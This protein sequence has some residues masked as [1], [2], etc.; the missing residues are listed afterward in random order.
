MPQKREPYLVRTLPRIR[1]LRSFWLSRAGA[2]KA[3]KGASKAYAKAKHN[4]EKVWQKWRPKSVLDV[5]SYIFGILAALGSLW[6][7]YL[8]VSGHLKN[9]QTMGLWVLYT[10]I[11]FIL[12]GAFLH[13]QKLIWEGSAKTEATVQKTDGPPQNTISAGDRPWLAVDVIPN[14]PLAFGKDDA[15]LQVRFVVFNTGRSVATSTT[16][17]AKVYVAKPG[18]DIWREAVEQQKKV[19]ENVNSTFMA[20]SVFPDRPYIQDINFGIAR[21]EFESARLADTKFVGSVFIVGCVDYQFG[22]QADHHQ[23]GFI[24][25]AHRRSLDN[26][27]IV[28]AIMYDEDIPADQLVFHKSIVGKGDYAN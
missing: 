19:C 14:G 17:N 22:E 18:G 23:T 6:L 28:L 9:H 13:F 15:V 11:I 8:G 26:P 16:I 4:A 25:E 27:N 1:P 24:Y 3:I 20:Y 10:T 12:T 5:L 2:D 7:G 21:R